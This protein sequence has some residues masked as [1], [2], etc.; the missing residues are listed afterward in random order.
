MIGEDISRKGKV[1][2]KGKGGFIWFHMNMEYLN[3][4]KSF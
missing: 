1:N 3:L 4:S 2:E